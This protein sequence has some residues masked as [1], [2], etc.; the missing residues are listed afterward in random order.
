MCEA[1]WDRRS[2]T[3][4]WSVWRALRSLTSQC[5]LSLLGS[6][7]T[8]CLRGGSSAPAACVRCCWHTYCVHVVLSVPAA[9]CPAPLPFPPSLHWDTCFLFLLPD[10]HQH[11]RRW[12]LVSAAWHTHSHSVYVGN[13]SRLG[14]T[15]QVVTG[16]VLW[17][18]GPFC[19]AG[20][21]PLTDPAVP[22]W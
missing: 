2:L 10:L 14:S 4:A 22:P 8:F 3:M 12:F 1:P 18:C 11:P 7:K 21:S 19:G 6:F 9:C 15:P 16:D 17:T 5:S 13:T 20:T